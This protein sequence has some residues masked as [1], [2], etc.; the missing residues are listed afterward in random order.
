MG[1]II[2]YKMLSSFYI[3]VS[4]EYSQL[5]WLW[6]LMLEELPHSYG[7]LSIKTMS[8]MISAAKGSD[9]VSMPSLC[10]NN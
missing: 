2:T 4:R 7:S 8:L 1:H 10:S 6:S 3:K 5:A 9:V